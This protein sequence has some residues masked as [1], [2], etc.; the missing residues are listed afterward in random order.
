LIKGAHAPFSFMTMRLAIVALTIINALLV[1]WALQ[2]L[3]PSLPFGL[4]FVFALPFVAA[5][6]RFF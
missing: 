4:A 1:A 2:A 5:I 3:L 6:V